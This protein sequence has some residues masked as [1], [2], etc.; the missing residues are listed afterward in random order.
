MRTVED[1]KVLRRCGHRIYGSFAN[2]GNRIALVSLGRMAKVWGVRSMEIY[3]GHGVCEGVG[4]VYI[5][6][7]RSSS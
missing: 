1:Q 5:R 7:T 4:L 2:G 3:F 6:L